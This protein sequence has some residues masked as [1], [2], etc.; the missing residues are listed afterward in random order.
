M[1]P[2]YTSAAV[3]P[4]W[5]SKGCCLAAVLVCVMA[6]SA[7]SDRQHRNPLDPLTTNPLDT[8]TPIDAIA[9]NGGVS[10]TWDYSQFE[11]LS[12]YRLHRSAFSID[13]TAQEL[14]VRDLSASTVQFE[15]LDVNNGRTY[16]YRLSLIVDGDGELELTGIELATPGP[17][18]AWAADAAAG[19]LWKLSPDGRNGLF[20]RGRFNF[21]GMAVNRH[22]RS[23]WVSDAVTGLH[24]IDVDGDVDPVQTELMEAGDLSLDPDGSLG[25]VADSA[26]ASVYSFS[27][28]SLDSLRLVQVDASFVDPFQM[29]AIGGGCWIADREQGRIL[30][31][32]AEGERVVD[33][34]GFSDLSAIAAADAPLLPN[35]GNVVWGIEEAGA[36]LLRFEVGAGG[37]DV[38][39]PFAPV[40]SIDVDDLTGNC[41]ALGESDI[42]LFGADGTP[43]THWSEVNLGAIGLTVDGHNGGVWLAAN[44]ALWKLSIELDRPTRLDGFISVFGIEVD[45]GM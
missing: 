30:L 41:W 3:W 16:Q 32:S 29:A 24:R 23:C 14:T 38:D 15:D 21:G 42:S 25:W 1:I 26:D 13:G 10:L 6:L 9:S 18:V 33:W 7:C 17:E 5:G 28:D 11:D 12:G 34:R 27:L 22:D 44:S 31:Y 36:R 43:L 4:L 45:P 19:L 39:L 35:G 37:L 40:L 8:S 2:L 20:A